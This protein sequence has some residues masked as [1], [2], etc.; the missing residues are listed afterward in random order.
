MNAWKTI[1]LATIAA[2]AATGVSLIAQQPATTGLYTPDQ[3]TAGRDL[4]TRSCASCHGT[5]LDGS[6]NAPSLSG[7]GFASFWGNKPANS[8]LDQ[9]KSTMPP[10]GIGSF[11]D[12]QYSAVV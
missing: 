8:L 3:A 12:E 4:Y 1:R 6:G 10:S 9:V 5:A 7:P 11:S 2:M